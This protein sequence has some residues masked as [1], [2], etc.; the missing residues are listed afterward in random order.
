MG[1]SRKSG[2]F[3][4]GA[5]WDADSINMLRELVSKGVPT[6]KIAKVM[7]RTPD[8]ITYQKGV[9]GLSTV[10]RVNTPKRGTSIELVAPVKESNSSTRDRAR[11]MARAAREIARSNG[12]RITMAM[13]FVEDL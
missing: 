7:G 13:F 3:N 12:K 11:D 6:K 8:S 2:A 10:S 1:N 4:D 5:R 9:Q